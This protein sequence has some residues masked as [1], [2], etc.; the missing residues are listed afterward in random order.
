VVLEAA[1]GRAPELWEVARV[2]DPL[3]QDGTLDRVTLNLSKLDTINSSFLAALVGMRKRLH[4]YG[5][6][7]V[8]CGLRPIVREVI[9]RIQFN[10][11]FEIVESEQ[12]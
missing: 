5:G 8:L 11:I 7:L 9:Y 10:R 4:A 3:C 1:P 6:T 2:V 12:C